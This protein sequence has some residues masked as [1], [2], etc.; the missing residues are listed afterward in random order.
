[1]I[2]RENGLQLRLEN[3][4]IGAAA[5]IG[6]LV[7]LIHVVSQVTDTLSLGLAVATLVLTL[8]Y[9]YFVNILCALVLTNRSLDS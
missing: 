5:W 7:G 2:T 4:S 6:G 9:G 1:M 3:F 8:S